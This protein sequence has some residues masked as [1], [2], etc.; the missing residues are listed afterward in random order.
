MPQNSVEKTFFT[1]KLWETLGKLWMNAGQ[2]DTQRPPARSF[3]LGQ[4]PPSAL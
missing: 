2:E 1:P 3:A 4:C